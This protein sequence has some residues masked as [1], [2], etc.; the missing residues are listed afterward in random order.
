MSSPDASSPPRA[1]GKQDGSDAPK[2]SP[3]KN[4]RVRWTLAVIGLLV[5]AALLVW[6]LHWLRVGRYLQE[7][8]NAYLQADAVAV[9]P[10]V[11]GYVTAVYV[12]DNQQVEAGQPLLQIDERTNKATWEQ[13]QAA[14][15]VRQADIAAAASALEGARTQLV[16]ARSQQQ[17]TSATLTFA[18]AEVKR[19]TPLAASGAD[20]H[21][22]VESLLHQREQARAQAAA[23]QAQV[24]GGA[25]NVAAAQ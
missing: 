23:A 22:H 12:Q 1:P 21:E 19:F 24:R 3:L 25:S 13:A 2:P 4:P 11:S 8:N 15:A 6:L 16:Q 14:V 7:T 9:A 20:T 18:E 5:L 10:R 17:A